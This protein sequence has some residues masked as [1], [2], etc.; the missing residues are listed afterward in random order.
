MRLAAALAV[1]AR[2]LHPVHG[3]R[4]DVDEMAARL[5]APL[6]TARPAPGTAATEILRIPT[7]PAPAPTPARV[8]PRP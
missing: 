3:R 5:A 2:E 6:P 8:E 7:A 4:S 1:V